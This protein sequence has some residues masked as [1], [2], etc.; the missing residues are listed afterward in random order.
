MVP[1]AR[2][3]RTSSLRYC[4]ASLKW[5]ANS[6]CAARYGR[7][8]K[9]HC[10]AVAESKPPQAILQANSCIYVKNCIVES[11]GVL[12]DPSRAT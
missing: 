6:N 7:L 11:V 10:N 5:K 8:K 4:K 3:T 2:V 1:P 9:D 12:L